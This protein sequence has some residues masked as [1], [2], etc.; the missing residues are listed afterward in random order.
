[1]DTKKLVR[2]ANQIAANLDYGQDR[3]ALVQ[4]VADHL[5]R[6]WTPDMK[7]E[8]VAQQRAGSA[9][10]NEAAGMAVAKLAEDQQNAA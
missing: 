4:S 7:Q 6:Y 8:I 9:E 1:M 2:M 3:A 10:L 5:R